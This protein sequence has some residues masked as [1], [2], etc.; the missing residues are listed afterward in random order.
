[1][2]KKSRAQKDTREGWQRR[3]GERTTQAK[4]QVSNAARKAIRRD[5]PAIN[6]L[7]KACDELQKEW[8]V[9]VSRPG[10]ASKQPSKA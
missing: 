6:V 3:D 2:G 4:E 7:A 5:I 9:Y 8:R 1:M 10:A